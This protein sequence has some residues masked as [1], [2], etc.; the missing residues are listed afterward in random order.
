[1]KQ[2]IDTTLRPGTIIDDR[3]MLVRQLGAGG[4][5]AVWLATDG[6]QSAAERDMSDIVLKILH[7]HFDR[8]SLAVKQLAREAE[9]LGQLAHPNIARPLAFSSNG[10]HTY[11]AMEF[12]EGR[13]LDQEIG[14]HT[15]TDT[16][17]SDHE[18][19]RLFGEICSAVSH[20]HSRAII[21]R[22]L[23]PQNVMVA[24]KGGSLF[25]KVLD[26]GIAKLLEGS[27]FDAT[28]FGRRI[29]SMFYMAPEQCKGES[30][31]VRSDIFSLGVML[32]EILTLR[33][34]WAW[35]QSERPLRAF[36]HP[37]PADGANAVS[38]VLM[39]VATA[40]R[41]RPT[42]ARPDLPRQLDDVLTRAM[43]IAPE[44]RYPTVDALLTTLSRVIMES[45]L[46][47]QTEVVTVKSRV[48][49]WMLKES[50]TPKEFSSPVDDS[51]TRLDQVPDVAVKAGAP[52][53]EPTPSVPVSR[54]SWRIGGK[55][56]PVDPTAPYD[57][58]RDDDG[59]ESSPSKA[60]AKPAVLYGGATG[61]TFIASA[62]EAPGGREEGTAAAPG[63]V[64]AGVKAPRDIDQE[65]KDYDLLAE[66][67]IQSLPMLGRVAGRSSRTDVDDT[68]AP[69]RAIPDPEATDR[70]DAVADAS[71]RA[72]S[73]LYGSQETRKPDDPNITALSASVIDPS[74][75]NP[76]VTG[77]SGFDPR[78]LEPGATELMF[79]VP[80]SDRIA[81]GVELPD[82]DTPAKRGKF[83]VVAQPNAVFG[84][85][86]G[87]GAARSDVS[88]TSK[89]L[90][91]FEETPPDLESD[92]SVRISPV[93]SSLRP[94]SETSP[95]FASFVSRH[96]LLIF[97]VLGMVLAFAIGVA[98]A[99]WA[100][101]HRATPVVEAIRGGDAQTA[102]PSAGSAEEHS[103]DQDLAPA[104]YA[105][106]DVLLAR[107]KT[108]PED[109]EVMNALRDQISRAADDLK[110]ETAKIAIKREAYASARQ[111]DV[112]ALEECLKKLRRAAKNR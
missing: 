73:L 54:S 27:L 25:V 50:S 84:A 109:Q 66:G 11:L 10:P 33:R 81:D 105:N 35:D 58:V 68:T 72:G 30:A 94:D 29:G 3:Y 51:D 82:E 46:E 4:C 5:G 63:G 70:R 55:H 78:A 34:A 108:S 92:S 110:S 37:L 67:I 106:L 79:A 28:T 104:P 41:P 65:T 48:P 14:A 49:S 111:K 90:T 1:L 97:G 102:A 99:Q 42:D 16:Y 32:F 36:E 52:I 17:F 61:G 7:P 74:E 22:D 18:V 23:K 15:R 89:T 91:G 77:A 71:T 93:S 47:F 40:P 64:M 76:S 8:Y 39:R 12:I 86:P 44:D 20:A 38:A 100:A 95:S 2:V 31:D 62:P 43:A 88:P 101:S 21:H 45:T 69:R 13:P 75:T 107:V 96:R 83:R 9:L 80:D 59:S 24:R 112:A 57:E 103:S 87:G 19:L 60:K 98:I 26:F 85:V 56:Q 53:S 6:G